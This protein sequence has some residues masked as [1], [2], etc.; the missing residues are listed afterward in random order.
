MIIKK[1]ILLFI[2]LI[3]VG[4]SEKLDIVEDNDPITVVYGIIDYTQ[5][6]QYIRISKTFT[7]EKS[8][9]DEAKSKNSIYYKDE[10]LNV[11]LEKYVDNYLIATYNLKRD[12]IYEKLSGL[13][14]NEMDIVYSINTSDIIYKQEYLYS[15]VEF[16]LVIHDKVRNVYVTAKTPLIGFFKPDQYITNPNAYDIVNSE[17]KEIK[18]TS[19]KNG[20]LYKCSLRLCYDVKNIVTN[21]IYSD[22]AEW[23][24]TPIKSATL[25]GKEAMSVKFF[26]DNFYY[27]FGTNIK[28]DNDVE[29]YFK[30]FKI[31]FTVLSDDVS[32]Y[33]EINQV[34]S[35]I[36]QEKPVYTNINNGIGLLGSGYTLVVQKKLTEKTLDS[37]K[38]GRY[39][40][41]LNFK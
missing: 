36:L 9:Y 21:E 28:E 32:K 37:L 3:L 17:S 26:V 25:E 6:K 41:K 22:S 20:R 11:Y 19:A 15:N 7:G 24:F 23:I 12:T 38:Y 18:W 5:N 4:C 31:I 8:V 13:F 34:S 16:K 35:D 1:S 10:E 27:Y 39:T 33:I 2:V 29:R 40:K 14:Y 30:N